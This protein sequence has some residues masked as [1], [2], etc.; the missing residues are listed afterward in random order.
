MQVSDT[1]HDCLVQDLSSGIGLVISITIERLED[2]VCNGL[3]HVQPSRL[4]AARTIS[5]LLK[6]PTNF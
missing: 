5:Q 3:A 4:S 1:S 6:S 2:N